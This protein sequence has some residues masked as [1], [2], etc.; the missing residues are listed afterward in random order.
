MSRSVKR[1]PACCTSNRRE[2]A[3]TARVVT[4]RLNKHIGFDLGISEIT[5]RAQHGRVMWKMG[6]DSLA[7]MR[8]N[9]TVS[10]IPNRDRCPCCRRASAASGTNRVPHASKQAADRPPDENAK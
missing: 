2:Q 1:Y 9:L 7:V 4:G 10:L 8:I 5:V 6:A 3:V